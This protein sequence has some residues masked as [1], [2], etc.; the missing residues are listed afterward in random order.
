VLYRGGKEQTIRHWL[1]ENNYVDTII[2]LP[3][4]LFFGVGI[5]TCIIILRKSARPDNKILFID[6]SKEFVKNGN[7]NRLTSENQE[8][9]YQVFAE[10]KEE[11][12]FSRL[13]SVD[14]VLEKEANL[15]VSGYVEQEDT[16]EQI[17]IEQVNANMRTLIAEGNTLNARIEEFIKELG[18]E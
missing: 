1:V 2:Q 15:S 5:A 10:R 11:K 6:A 18:G 8:H 12:Y 14:E 4:N 17:D 7:K 16:R 9:I 3:G 13:V